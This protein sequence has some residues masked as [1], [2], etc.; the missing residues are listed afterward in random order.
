MAKS[1]TIEV[2]VDDGSETLTRQVFAFFGHTLIAIGTWGAMMLIGYVINPPYIP[3]I[4]ISILSL[5]VPLV[6]GMLI[7]SVRPSEMAPHVWLAGII[8][9][10]FLSL[11]LL[12]LPTGPNACNQCAATEKIV[13]SFFS[14]PTPSGLIDDNG[15]FFGTWPAIATI[16]YGIG[17]A[18]VQARRKK[19]AK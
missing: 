7:V 14:Y 17:A 19:S 11:W 18:I 4:V 1:V 8:W 5:L 12:D 15:P 10:L 9:M 3:Q 2:E 6:A 13:R 16:G